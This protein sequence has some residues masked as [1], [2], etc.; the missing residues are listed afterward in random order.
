MI[1]HIFHAHIPTSIHQRKHTEPAH[2]HDNNSRTNSEPTAK[3]ITVIKRSAE[4][5]CRAR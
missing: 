3:Q 1:T 4:L 2:L 5:N